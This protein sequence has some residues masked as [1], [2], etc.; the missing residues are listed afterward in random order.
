[1]SAKEAMGIV[2]NALNVI[3]ICLILGKVTNIE[4]GKKDT[5][6]DLLYR[7]VYP[8]AGLCIGTILAYLI[9]WA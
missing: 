7:M 3:A 2:M 9:K 4:K 6:Y 8:A 1:M 5:P